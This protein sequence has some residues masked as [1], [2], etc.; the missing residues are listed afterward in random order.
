MT[1]VVRRQIKLHV[2]QADGMPD[3]DTIAGLRAKYCEHLGFQVMDQS[4]LK[5]R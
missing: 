4:T 5:D 3:E 2:S 1:R